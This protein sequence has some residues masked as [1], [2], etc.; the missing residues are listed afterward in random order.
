LLAIH[1]EQQDDDSGIIYN[2]RAM[3]LQIISILASL[4]AGPA[5]AQSLTTP[6]DP[7]AAYIAVPKSP[8]PRAS[9]PIPPAFVSFSIEFSSFPDYAGNK[10]NPN[11]FSEN[12]LNN[13]A[14]YQGVKP[15]I[16]VG[17]NTQ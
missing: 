9:A 6:D 3:H 12:L 14:A 7:N 8:G 17:G 10:A 2:I 15:I 5:T 1:I 11:V 13:I 4:T 16:R